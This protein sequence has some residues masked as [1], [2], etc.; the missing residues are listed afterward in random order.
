MKSS[1]KIF[2]IILFISS[3]IFSQQYSSGSPEWLV[4]MFFVKNSFPEKANYYSGEMLNFADDPTIGEKL[5][6][7]AIVNFHQI[8]TAQSE[9]FFKIEV[10]QDEKII[11][12]YCFLYEQ[13]NKW[14]IN[15]VRRFLLPAFIYT[16]RDSLSKVGSLP[17]NDS[18]L[19][20]TLKL[21]TA[22]DGELMQYLETNL[23]NLRELVSAFDNNIKDEINNYLALVGCNAIY[24]DAKYPGCIFIQIQRFENMEC[25]FINKTES[26]LI[27]EISIK[28]FIYIE[29]VNS[30]WYIYRMM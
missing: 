20:L 30:E 5:A 21:F 19:L 28:D 2:S 24:A 8:K 25:G 14:T 27:P 18:T 9:A 4:D 11:D 23:K 6:G 17:S 16:V 22:S 29:E 7:N 10:E 12:F 15:A 13:D 3:Q 1:F 26:A